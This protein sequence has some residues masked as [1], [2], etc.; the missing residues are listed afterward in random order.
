MIPDL[1]QVIRGLL[2]V[3]QCAI[4]ILQSFENKERRNDFEKTV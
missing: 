4:I 1:N 3:F 2:F